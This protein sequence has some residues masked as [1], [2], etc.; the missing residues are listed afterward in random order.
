MCGISAILQNI[1]DTSIKTNAFKS[2][3]QLENRGYDSVGFFFENY[4]RLFK[5]VC[6]MSDFFQEFKNV[7]IQ[8]HLSIAH[9]RWATHGKVTVKN[10]HP[11]TSYDGDI[12]IVHNGI[13]NNCE[14]IRARL[15]AKQ[16]FSRSETDTEVICNL[17]RFNETR[18]PEKKFEHIV[19]MTM[20]ELEGTWGIVIYN[21]KHKHCLYTTS[22]GCPVLVGYNRD[23]TRFMIASEKSGFAGLVD[24]YVVLPSNKTEKIQLPRPCGKIRSSIEFQN[25]DV[26]TLQ[27]D[28]IDESP[29]PFE[30]W[31]LKEIHDQPEKIKSVLDAYVSSSTGLVDF[32]E[33]LDKLSL[34]CIEHIIFLACGT[35]LN[36]SMLGSQ[37]LKETGRFCTVQAIDASEFTQIDIPKSKKNLFILVSQS[38]ETKDVHRALR[39]VKSQNMKTLSIVNVEDSLIARESDSVLYT[40]VG[41]EYGVASTKCFTAQVLVLKLLSL[42]CIHSSVESKKSRVR[43]L[44]ALPFQIRTIISSFQ[45]MCQSDMLNSFNKQTM[46]ILGRQKT[47]PIAREAA[48]K[49]KEIS[50][51]HSESFASGSLKHGPLALMNRN[52]PVFLI[53]IDDDT[54][55]KMNHV[56]NE[57]ISRGA[58]VIVIGQTKKGEKRKENTTSCNIPYNCETNELLAIIPFQLIAYYLSLKKGNNP[59]FPRNL[60]K[61]VVVY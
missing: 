54:Y 8:S 50:Y 10:C 52:L 37:Y 40:R 24:H 7:N 32:G 55:D 58:H 12:I 56:H 39:I 61:S 53:K 5:S 57:I 25:L 60:A 26:Y 28:S 46:V 31:T 45:K 11:H 59:D 19:E 51:I 15:E 35:S 29:S 18:H 9:T 3:Q 4:S 48:L 1:A 38:G 6:K 47:Y 13:I 49:I 30:H 14:D 17:L 16:I 21:Q 20:K 36:A 44:Y 34:E 22:S 2:I 27:S 43:S 42:Y 23:K 33:E 41:K